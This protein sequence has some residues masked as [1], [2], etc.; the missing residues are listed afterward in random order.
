MLQLLVFDMDGVIVDTEY[1]D[2]QLQQA[3]VCLFSSSPN[4]LS[5]QD[6]SI[7]VGKSYTALY[8]CI[9]QLSQTSLSLE[10]IGHQLDKF[11]AEKYQE[12]NYQELFQKA[13]VQILLYARKNHIKVALV[14]SF[15]YQHIIEVLTSCGIKEYFDLIVSGEDFAESKPNPAIYQVILEKLDIN[16]ENAVAIE[17]SFCGI[18]AVKSA[19]LKIIVYEEKRMPVDQ[20]Q[21]DMVAK[22]M[23]EIFSIL[24]TLKESE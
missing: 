12:V 6:F 22:D 4:E 3:F 11:A 24:Q 23:I 2:F 21:A 9:K 17:N 10:T 16:V 5:Q 19:G 1:L 14:S 15:R 18:A 8:R 20:S 7:L 13:I